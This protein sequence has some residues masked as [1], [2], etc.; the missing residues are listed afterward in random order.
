MLSA[1]GVSHT[2]RRPTNEDAFLASDAL[3]LF[4]VADGMGGHNAGEVASGIAVRTIEDAVAS[5]NTSPGERLGEAIRLANR[6]VL[7]AAG[8]NHECS[9]MGTTVVAALVTP[10]EVHYA[11]IGDSRVYL[12]HDARLFQLT[13]DDTWLAHVLAS[14]GDPGRDHPMRHVLTRVVGLRPDLDVDVKRMPFESGDVLLLCS[15][16]L[17]GTIAD[18]RIAATLGAGLSPNDAANGLVTAALDAGA[19]DNVTAVVMQQLG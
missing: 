4:V 7:R 16:G 19:T 14:G 18:A 17:H 9:G 11:G 13:H 2:G 12:F 5:A 3:G 10:G 15:D 6:E 8:R 1:Y